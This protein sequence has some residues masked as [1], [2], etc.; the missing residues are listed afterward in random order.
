MATT[1]PSNRPATGDLAG[2]LLAGHAVATA[3]DLLELFDRLPTVG[4]DELRG[5]YRGSEIPTGHPMDG[6]LTASAWY[7]KQFDGPEAVHPLLFRAAGTVFPVDPRRLPVGI[8]DRVPTA[9]LRLVGR[10][11]PLVRPVLAT[12]GHCARLRA[13]EHRGTVGAAMVYDHLPIID[14]FRRLD[15]DVLLGAMD[16]RGA[17]EPY[18]FLLRRDPGG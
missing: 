3:D 7:G 6:V 14:H 15:D 5:R 4:V 10:A 11:M 1:T 8:A 13:V 18:F 16:Q 2:A 12:R 9:A 17:D